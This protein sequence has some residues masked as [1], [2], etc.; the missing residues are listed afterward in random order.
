MNQGPDNEAEKEKKKKDTLVKK[1]LRFFFS[2]VGLF[3]LLAGYSIGGAYYF[4]KIEA[5]LE[6]KAKAEMLARAEFIEGSIEYIVDRYC[7]S[8]CVSVCI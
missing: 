8:C 1:V 2:F 3:F 5:P 6:A 4:Y 7:R